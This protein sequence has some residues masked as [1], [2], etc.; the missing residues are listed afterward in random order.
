[1]VLG[2]QAALVLLV[3]LACLSPHRH[4][5]CP[6]I[7][8]NMEKELMGYSFLVDKEHLQHDLQKFQ[9]LHPCLRTLWVPEGPEMQGEGNIY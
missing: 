9:P 5:A 3:I 4:Q 6:V 1:M 8:F 7:E 2:F